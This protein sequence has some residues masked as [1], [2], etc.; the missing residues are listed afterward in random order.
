MLLQVRLVEPRSKLPPLL[1][2]IS[3]EEVF[4][5]HPNRFE[6]TLHI[7]KI[8]SLDFVASTSAPDLRTFPVRPT[9][10]TLSVSVSSLTLT[11]LA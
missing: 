7:S 6:S 2:H 1:Y 8:F 4:L 3:H 10:V 9:L 11:L 5:H